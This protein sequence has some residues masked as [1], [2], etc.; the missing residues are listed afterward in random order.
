MP[1]TQKK[2]LV[3]VLEHIQRIIPAVVHVLHQQGA[4]QAVHI[5]VRRSAPLQVQAAPAAA[6]VTLTV[7]VL[8]PAAQAGAVP[9]SIS[10]S[11]T[12]T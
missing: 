11:P 2:R 6:A 10:L 1:H 8:L 3:I 7:T 4:G 5:I 12:S 9:L